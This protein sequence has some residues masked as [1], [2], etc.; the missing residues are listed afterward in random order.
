MSVLGMALLQGPPAWAQ[1]GVVYPANG[2]EVSYAEL[3]K[4]PDWRGIWQPT[5]G[6][7]TGD[8]PRLKGRYREFYEAE[9]AKVAADPSYEIPERG[10]NCLAPGM[11]AMMTMPYS[12]EFL[13]TPGKIVI[14]Q[15]A[16]M[17]VR[18][19]FTDGRPFPEDP[20]PNFFG[21]SIGHWEG[22]T[23]VVETIGTREG[24]RLGV[25]GITNGPNLKITERIYLDPNNPD[26][27]H[28]DFS[29]ED[30]D[31]LE[32]PWHQ[33]HTFR[34]DRTWDI[35]EYICDENDRHPIGEDGQ[36]RAVLNE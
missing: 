19:I 18:R 14:N 33:N 26:L 9:R 15:E 32:A 11:P 22:E 5:F 29:Y 27:L 36:T 31:V 10:S 12:L 4:L 34:R 24:Q 20:D 16:H 23:L 13:F 6:R 35:L 30:P 21:Y 7:V 17:Q 2:P 28:L 25:L 8:Q 3:D 1:D